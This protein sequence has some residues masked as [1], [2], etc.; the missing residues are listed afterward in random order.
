MVN[1][2]FYLLHVDAPK[3]LSKKGYD[4]FRIEMTDLENGDKGEAVYFREKDEYQ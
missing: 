3:E 1:I 2:A 4:I